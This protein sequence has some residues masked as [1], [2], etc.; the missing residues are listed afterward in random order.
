MK[1]PEPYTFFVDRALGSK[2]IPEALRAQGFRVEA[3][4]DH[5][6]Q[7]TKD[8]EWLTAIGARRW[9]ILTKDSHIRRNEVEKKALLD[10]GVAAFMLGNANLSGLV[11]AGVFAKAMPRMQNVLRRYAPPIIATVGTDAGVSVLYADSAWIK[12]PRRV[13]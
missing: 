2:A 10:A 4:D 13:K 7:K 5:F 3:H 9:V 6:D 8:V 12:P 11:M 1:L